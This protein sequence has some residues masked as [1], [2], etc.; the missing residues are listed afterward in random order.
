[1]R[2]K[3]YQADALKNLEDFLQL[4]DGRSI[5]AAFKN[6]WSGRDVTAPEY[7][8]NIPRVPQVCLKVPTG[9]GKTFMAAASLKKIFDALPVRNKV[10]VWL[11]PSETILTQT[12]KNLSDATHAYHQRLAADFDGQVAVYDKAQLLAGENFSPAEVA[13]QV[14]ILVLSY[15]S[16]RTSNKDG[17]KAYRQNG[18]LNQFVA[19][20]HD[21]EEILSGADESSLIQVIR[22]YNPIVIV[23]E[24]H[25]ATTSLSVEMLK[26][27]NPRF[28]LELTATPKETSN[29]IAYVPATE[30]KRADMVKLP[31]IVYNRPTQENVI[32][33]AIDFRNRL[34][35]YGRH[36]GVRPIVL[37][38]AESQGRGDRATFDRIKAELI[39]THNIAAEEIAVKTAEVNDLRGVDLMAADC[40]VRYIITINALKEGWDCPFAYILASLANRSSVVDVEQILGRILRRPF[41][42][43]FSEELLNQSYVFTS[44][45]EFQ[46]TL[47]KIIV[48]LNNSGFS[49][50]SYRAIEDD[51][52]PENESELPNV[53]YSDKPATVPNAEIF[54]DE[55]ERPKILH[56]EPT[57]PLPNEQK[58]FSVA[59]MIEQARQVNQTYQNDDGGNVRAKEER[60]RMTE[61]S[62]RDRFGADARELILPKFFLREDRT[63]LFGNRYDELVCRENL[64]ANLKLSDKDTVIN[65]DNLRH[66]IAA[67]DVQEGE[68]FP[69]CKFLSDSEIKALLEHFDNLTDAAQIRE[70][71]RKIAAAV[72]KRRKTPATKEIFAYVRRIVETFDRDRLRD[73]IINTHVY[74]NKITEK[75]NAVTTVHAKKFFLAQIDARKIFTAPAYKLPATIAPAE[76]QRWY[77][78]LYAAEEKTSN[79]FEFRI[80]TALTRLENVLWWHRNRATPKDGFCLNGFINHYPDFIVRMKSG[81]VLLVESKGDDRDNSDSKQKLELGKIWESKA[82]SDKFGYFMVFE[83]ERL[84][85]ALSF[86][87]FFTRAKDL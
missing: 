12:Y 55:S 21:D 62:M 11:V 14:S 73:A 27:F 22:H 43:K 53:F 33:D 9:G 35:D 69:S 48:G 52:P 10:V 64:S 29:V 4:L 87:D 78:S 42:K 67:L 51:T 66:E 45:A 6:F 86:D 44:S 19:H 49:E 37:F 58:I 18:Q 71:S 50:R 77:N 17:R 47:E 13:E 70:C 26:N 61:F 23:D 38:Q 65:F 57:A 68:D 60:E 56:T 85:G 36:E 34:E 31:V 28:I 2:L 59:E 41:T 82:G 72:D 80:A 24:S 25:H 39:G 1:M 79:R 84:D 15:D 5:S 20:F 40:P 75:I 46:Q 8:N 32:S 16:F 7:Q 83:S 54:S 81:V 76:I 63:D 30:L 74:A 3:N